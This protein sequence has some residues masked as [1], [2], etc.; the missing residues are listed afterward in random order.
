MTMI[1]AFRR[2][3][4]ELI[5]AGAPRLYDAVRVTVTKVGELPAKGPH[6]MTVTDAGN[7][8]DRRPRYTYVSAAKH[9]PTASQLRAI[10]WHADTPPGTSIALQVRSA[11]TQE[12]LAQAPWEGANGENS[13]FATPT[14][15]AKRPLRG[16]WVQYQAVFANPGGGLPV[17][18]SVTLD[19]D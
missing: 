9:F 1:D 19:L 11:A 4:R 6:L 5:I 7:V 2:A 13:D 12:S 17:L 3:Q 14:T 16:P 10:S 18:R 8:F 15:T